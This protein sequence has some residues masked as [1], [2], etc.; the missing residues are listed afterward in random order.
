MKTRLLLPGLTSVHSRF[1]TEQ[2]VRESGLAS[3]GQVAVQVAALLPQ[4]QL[5]GFGQ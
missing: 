1:Q 5:A 2:Q 3:P 4:I